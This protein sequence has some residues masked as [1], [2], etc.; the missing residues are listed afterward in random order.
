ME[1]LLDKF[2]RYVKVETTSCELEENV[3]Y[4]LPFSDE[5]WNSIRKNMDYKFNALHPKDVSDN[6]EGDLKKLLELMADLSIMSEPLSHFTDEEWR[7]VRDV[8]G[9][10]IEELNSKKFDEDK[11]PSSDKQWGLIN[12]LEDELNALGVE[13]RVSNYGYVYAFLKSN[14]DRDCPKLCFIAHVDTS[15]DVSGKDVKPKVIE[16][17]DGEEIYLG[18]GNY[19][20]PIDYP[21]LSSF[22]G[23]TL[24]T[25]S[26]DT[27]L[28]A[29]DKA[30]VSEIMCLVEY[31]VNNP[32]VKHGDICIA[33]TPDEE[34]GRGSEHFDVEGFNADFGYTVDGGTLGE[35]EYE[36]FNAASLTVEV[37]GTTIHPGSAKN[38]M[39]NAI[40]ILNE[41]DRMLPEYMR[42]EYTEGYEGF[43]HLHTM[44]GSVDKATAHYLI[45]EHNGNRFAGKKARI[46]GI[47]DYLNNEYGCGTVVAE[48]KDSYYNMA[49]VIKN[50]FHL[51]D[52][53][54]LAME[55]ANVT[56]AVV[57]IRG[58]TDG[59]R[60]S[61]MNLPCANLSTGGQNYHSV[62]EYACLEDMETMVEVLKNL[63][64][65][66][67]NF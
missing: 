53:A 35:I 39:V 34:V 6:V 17:Y 51:V 63:V 19:L 25:T 66:Y 45:R 20:S 62:Y 32:D 2:L 44:T 5:D 47:V 38:K 64:E 15:P 55:K 23:K 13:N 57:P 4:E 10:K 42:P 1:K 46:N 18:K 37:N 61:F 12:M 28:G 49:D 14:I 30:G 36:N 22:K 60:L 67:A 3:K 21:L 27:L 65:I 31:L 7:V 40:R 56:P 59:A 33:F 43:Y 8:I 41:F 48:I 29:D 58:G 54:R 11:Q 50:H 26:G 9:D 52:N 16:N 24:I